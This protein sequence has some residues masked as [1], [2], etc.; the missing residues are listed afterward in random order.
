VAHANQGAALRS[1]GRLNDARRAYQRAL[2]LKLV[3]LFAGPARNNDATA[4]GKAAPSRDAAELATIRKAID[5]R[6]SRAAVENAQGLLARHPE[7]PDVL[8]ANAIAREANREYDAALAFVRRAVE[9]RGDRSEFHISLARLLLR[10]GDLRP[11][12]R[13]RAPRCGWSRLLPWCTQ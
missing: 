9:R 6:D 1:L 4:A 12:S 7:D 3:G 8:H 11:L 10:A 2:W 5:Q 13:R